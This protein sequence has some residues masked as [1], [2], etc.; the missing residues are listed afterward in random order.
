VC[1]ELVLS[2]AK[3][4]QPR[5]LPIA[6]PIPARA[7]EEQTLN[8]LTG[9]SDA[10]WLRTHVRD[11]AP[12]L[13]LG[14][15]AILKA[16]DGTFTALKFLKEGESPAGLV[17]E[18]ET[19]TFLNDLKGR[20]IDLRSE[21]PRAALPTDGVLTRIPR[22]SLT[23][24]L[25]EA[26]RRSG[27]ITEYKRAFPALVYTTQKD[28]YFRYAHQL[29][30]SSA[31]L[32]GQR[33]MHDVFLLARHGVIHPDIIELF[34]NRIQL[35]RVDGGKYIPMIDF[36]RPMG[37]RQG[38]GRLHSWQ[39]TVRYPNFG[40]SG[41]RD[42]AELAELNDL[43]NLKNPHT[44]HLAANLSRFGP[45][46]QRNGVLT[47]YLSNY[48][49]AW[50]LVEG[51]RCADSGSFDVPALAADMREIYRTSHGAFT[52]EADDALAGAVDWTRYARQMQYFMGSAYKDSLEVPADV[53]GLS[54]IAIHPGDGWGFI[55]TDLIREAARADGRALDEILPA[56]GPSPYFN[57]VVSNAREL[58]PGVVVVSPK[59]D[60][61]AISG[62]PGALGELIRTHRA[63]WRWDGKH[64]DL[65]PVNGPF[66]LQEAVKAMY[67]YSLAMVRTAAH[68]DRAAGLLN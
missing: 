38:A 56:R 52:G 47:N 23:E 45:G 9:T 58:P 5:P 6:L 30:R 59:L 37:T 67:L 2:A 54:G 13:V 28:D 49:L 14:R 68:S 29:D 15:T 32:A 3:P 21:L 48:L 57:A 35:G 4:F 61:A 53:F 62:I 33:A 39:E 42:V 8:E 11:A 25:L 46:I 12:H 34:H 20:G 24:G 27:A 43:S 7:R 64:E 51:K 36:V 60:D 19:L 44:A 55:H 50:T 18:A 31:L 10:K 40:E 17:R 1:A 65:G 22:T 16:R 66:P 26:I 41:L 63:G